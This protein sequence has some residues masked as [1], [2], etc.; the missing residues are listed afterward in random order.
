MTFDCFGTDL[1]RHR[2]DSRQQSAIS[3]QLLRS[4]R[5]CVKNNKTTDH[6]LA[7]EKLLVKFGYGGWVTDNLELF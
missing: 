7:H 4:P 5:M 1:L 3:T 6:D 2:N